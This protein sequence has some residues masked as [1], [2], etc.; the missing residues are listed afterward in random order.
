M[1][2]KEI[3]DERDPQLI[4]WRILDSVKLL[5]K[6]INALIKLQITIMGLRVRL[7]NEIGVFK[8]EHPQAMSDD[9]L[10][11]LIKDDALPLE[12]ILIAFDLNKPRFEREIARIQKEKQK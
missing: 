11:A 10:Y 6:S 9:L 1:S 5:S 4:E 2:N 12:E 7:R 8:A 3:D